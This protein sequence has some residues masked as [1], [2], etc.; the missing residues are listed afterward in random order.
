MARLLHWLR[1]EEGQALVE[2]GLIIALVSIAVITLLGAVGTDLNTIFTNIG[3]ALT[4][5]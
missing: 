1:R 3:N 2:Y 5:A 4:G